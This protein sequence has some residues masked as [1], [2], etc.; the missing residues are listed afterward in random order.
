MVDKNKNVLAGLTMAQSLDDQTQSDLAELMRKVKKSGRIKTSPIEI[1]I[2]SESIQNP[3]K[4]GLRRNTITKKQ[5]GGKVQKMEGGGSAL[6]PDELLKVIEQLKEQGRVAGKGQELS[7]SQNKKIADSFEANFNKLF[8]K[9]YGG[10]IKKM[11]NGG[12]T[13]NSISN[14]DIAKLE[15]LM[16]LMGSGAGKGMPA[17]GENRKDTLANALMAGGMGAGVGRGMPAQKQQIDTQ[18]F[19]HGGSVKGKKSKGGGCHV[20]A[21]AQQSKVAV[22]KLDRI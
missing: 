2:R 19:E 15:A 17:Q 22:S 11:R 21:W 3:G 10:L 8:G 14:A 12:E 18:G 1:D 9:K 5:Y 7:S 13:G 20:V 4:F 6:N 16:K